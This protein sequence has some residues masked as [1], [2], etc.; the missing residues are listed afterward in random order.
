MQPPN[1]DAKRVRQSAPF[2]EPLG[3]GP[4][5]T[6]EDAPGLLRV[7]W[8]IRVPKELLRASI[9]EETMRHA[10]SWIAVIAVALGISSSARA[11]ARVTLLSPDPLKR[12]V[13]EIVKNF[14]KKTGY[15][16]QQSYG[17]GVSTRKTVGEGGALDVTLLFAPFD[18]ALK[19]GNVDKS[20][21]TVVAQV[22]LALAV[23]E[24][25]PSPDISNEAAVKKL[26]LNAK[27]VSTV[28]PAQGSVGGAAML[29]F[30][31]MGITDQLKPKLKLFSGGGGPQQS[32]R[33]GETEIAVG[34]YLSDY[35]DPHAGLNLVGALPPDAAPPIDIT[36]WLSTNVG[37]RKAAME[38][39]QYFKSSEANAVWKA[40][41]VFP[42]AN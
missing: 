37:D 30:D 42:V 41:K 36:G 26:L 29:A 25:V 35:R 24:G 4:T 32:V 14:E 13:D 23:K 20:T 7:S 1:V 5:S 22:R 8:C 19:G 10:I 3:V 18:D 2:A 33:D 6:G 17:T 16:V 15:T 34:P 9:E 27:S 38:L 11:Q 21:Q 39:L 12:E 28:D 40:A 31:H